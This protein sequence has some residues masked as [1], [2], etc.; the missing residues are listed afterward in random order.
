MNDWR[1]RP[2]RLNEA[3]GPVAIDGDESPDRL[4]DTERPRTCKK[5]V[6]ARQRA[7]A[8]KGQ[9]EPSV[10]AL[11]GVHEHHERQS[12]DAEQGQRHDALG[13][14]EA[15]RLLPGRVS[16]DRQDNRVPVLQDLESKERTALV[17]SIS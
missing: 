13:E 5:A 17:F 9:H 14:D 12:D 2:F 8:S 11:K 1:A 10:A 15:E 3:T 4:D 7:A 6:R 16:L